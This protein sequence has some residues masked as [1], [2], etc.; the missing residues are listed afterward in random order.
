MIVALPGLF[1]YLFLMYV[2]FVFTWFS[3]SCLVDALL[4][5]RELLAY[6]IR[7]T[8]NYTSASKKGKRKVQGVPQSQT[9]ALPRPKSCL[10]HPYPSRGKD[11]NLELSRV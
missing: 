8:A 6:R 11:T 5:N 3:G 4:G 10:S 9:A 1:S 2:Y 7:I